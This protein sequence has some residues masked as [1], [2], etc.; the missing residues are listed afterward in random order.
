M[1]IFIYITRKTPAFGEITLALQESGALGG[2]EKKK[3]LGHWVSLH[4]G[5]QCMP[6]SAAIKNFFF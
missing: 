1:C 3:K 5:Q 2:G 6:P 4:L